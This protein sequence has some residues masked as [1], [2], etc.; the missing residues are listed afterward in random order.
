MSFEQWVRR[1]WY[2]PVV[3]IFF[4]TATLQFLS[5]TYGLEL[6]GRLGAV[7]GVLVAWSLSYVL[8]K[9]ENKSE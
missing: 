7:I 5:D 1:R 4:T 2:I 9:A 8:Y 3:I 6:L